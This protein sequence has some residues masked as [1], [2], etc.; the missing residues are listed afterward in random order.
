MADQPPSTLIVWLDPA[1]LPFV[2]AVAARAKL[3]IV[4]AGSPVR[5]RSGEVAEALGAAPIDDLRHALLSL[6]PG[7]GVGKARGAPAE[8]A[9]PTSEECGLVWLA[10]VERA[11][12]IEPAVL[13]AMRAAQDRGATIVSSE[14]V[15]AAVLELGSFDDQSGV[16]GPMTDSTVADA[17]DSANP[18]AGWPALVPLFRAGKT[19]PDLTD[20]LE[21]FGPARTIHFESLGLAL[22]CSLGAR[23]LDAMDTVRSLAGEPED[24]YAT[25][26]P[27]LGLA[28]TTPSK[29]A[30]DSLR[31]LSGTL[32]VNMR[33]SDGRAASVLVSDAGGEWRRS[34]TLLGD[35]NTAKGG[36]L[37]ITDVALDWL[38]ADG[39]VLERTKKRR[40]IGP[41]SP[42]PL[43][44]AATPPVISASADVFAEALSAVGRRRARSLPPMNHVGVL[45][46]TG[47]ALLSARTG[48]PESPITIRRMV[49]AG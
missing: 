48:Q 2:Q 8:A 44:A 4:A 43:F 20:S 34:L 37:R 32:S 3:R 18:D 28:R 10:S 23:L 24:L 49:G 9:S 7:E 42:P 36:R 16:L 19:M 47:A 30:L 39:T 25:H 29:S 45:A 12:A 27:T 35:P 13:D 33:F 15:P 21:E 40:T 1:Q 22:E 14:P 41:V 46:M 31:D 5:G 26:V 6:M 17:M 11:A 38:G